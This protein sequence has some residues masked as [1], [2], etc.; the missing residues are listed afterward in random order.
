VTTLPNIVWVVLFDAR[1]KMTVL[2]KEPYRGTLELRDGEDLILEQDVCLS[3][4]AMFGPDAGDVA[5]WQEIAMQ[6]IDKRTAAAVAL[7]EGIKDG[8]TVCRHGE[9]PFECKECRKEMN[10]G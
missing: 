4:D 5:E 6:F 9:R 1:Y 7:I 3:Y 10:N 8:E 2:R